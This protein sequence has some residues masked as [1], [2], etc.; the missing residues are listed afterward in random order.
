M[1][2]SGKEKDWNKSVFVDKSV[3]RWSVST[4]LEVVMRSGCRWS[5]STLLV[6]VLRSWCSWS[7][8][9]LLEVVMRSGCRWSVSTLLVAVLRSWCSWS[10]SK[11]L[12]SDTK[13]FHYIFNRYRNFFS[14]SLILVI[15]I[16]YKWLN[17][18]WFVSRRK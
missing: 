16:C 2:S 9:T 5:V 4:L 6:A 17:C 15:I 14:I 13:S 7:V 8:S 12:D 1:S 18:D 11:L 3:C 10:V